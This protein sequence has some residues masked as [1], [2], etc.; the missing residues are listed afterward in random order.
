M[1]LTGKPSKRVKLTV[2]GAAVTALQT[3]F[4]WF[5]PCLKRSEACH[6]IGGC[7]LCKEYNPNGNAPK[8]IGFTKVVQDQNELKYHDSSDCHK[9]AMSLAK[10]AAG[11]GP[12]DQCRQQAA[13]AAAAKMADALQKEFRRLK[14]K[15]ALQAE[16][17]KAW[18]P[19][20][21]AVARDAHLY[22]RVLQLAYISSVL[23]VQTACVE[24]GFSR[25]R[26][27]KTRLSSR[28]RLVTVDAELRMGLLAPPADAAALPLGEAAAQAGRAA[29]Q[30]AIRVIWRAG[31]HGKCMICMRTVGLQV[32]AIHRSCF[33]SGVLPFCCRTH[34]RSDLLPSGLTTRAP[35]PP[36][37]WPCTAR[38][39]TF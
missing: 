4:P 18:E 17:G 16:L 13:A 9:K 38:W 36:S 19:A 7:T 15:L 30:G 39:L 10:A 29:L 6:P 25:H 2:S 1:D 37:L 21:E 33:C 8:F 3:Q 20:Y 11:Q 12:L 26:L 23:P 27:V 28:K 32:D 24:R 31:K 14:A 34:G 22:P 5:A 35:S